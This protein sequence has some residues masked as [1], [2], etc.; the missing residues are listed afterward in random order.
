MTLSDDCAS[1]VVVGR[2]NDGSDDSIASPR[3]AEASVL[4]GIGRMKSID[5]VTVQMSLQQSDA[6]QY[7]IFFRSWCIARTTLHL[8]SGR[9]VLHNISLLVEN[10]ELA[11]E[12]LLIGYPVL[13]HPGIDS[14]TLLESNSSALDGTNCQSVG[15]PTASP[16]GRIGRLMV[17]ARCML[18]ANLTNR[19]LIVIRAHT[20]LPVTAHVSFTNRLVRKLIHS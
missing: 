1:L 11:C 6:V 9:L 4:K 7:F 17:A 5:P 3:V 18:K 10:D 12:D 20:S 14:K 19:V 15:N 13:Q 16:T 2:S 8:S